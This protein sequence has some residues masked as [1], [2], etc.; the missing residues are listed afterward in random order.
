MLLGGKAGLRCG[1]IMALEWHDVDLH[2]ATRRVD[3]LKMAML[4]PMPR[5]KMENRER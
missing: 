2:C 5:P 3:S 1:E 4:T